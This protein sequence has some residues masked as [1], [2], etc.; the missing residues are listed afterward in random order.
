MPGFPRKLMN[1]QIGPRSGGE[2]L[3]DALRIHGVDTAFC[4]PGE[5]FLAVLDAL[6]G[7]R[8]EIS[9]Y[10]SIRMHQERHY[11]ERVYSTDLVNPDFATL[12]RAYGAHSECVERSADF[13]AAFERALNAGTPALIELRTDP[14]VVSPRATVSSLRRQ[15]TAG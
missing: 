1:E 9:M 5:S 7:A 6:Y 13:P 8:E 12:A 14:E 15:A 2:V 11:P 10:G 3:V 4:A